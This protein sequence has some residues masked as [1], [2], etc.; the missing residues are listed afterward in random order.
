MPLSTVKRSRDIT[1]VPT[2]SFNMAKRHRPSNATL[3]GNFFRQA[4]SSKRSTSTSTSGTLTL[5][6][7]SKAMGRPQLQVELP[8]TPSFEFNGLSP[9][10]SFLSSSFHT[11]FKF[12]S[13]AGFKGVENTD[14]CVNREE[15]LEFPRNEVPYSMLYDSVTPEK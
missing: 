9:I 6:P 1:P 15:L 12:P 11:D 4:M 5:L 3:V 7:Q 8:P 13:S 14:Q 2:H 10:T